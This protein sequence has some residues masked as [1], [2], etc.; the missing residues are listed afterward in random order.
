MVGL[1]I[2]LKDSSRED[3]VEHSLTVGSISVN[4]PN[5]V[6]F[7]PLIDW[8]GYQTFDS[9]GFDEKSNWPSKGDEVSSA[10]VLIQK[11]E[12]IWI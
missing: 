9:N 1:R 3:Q 7:G 2:V 12:Q 10:N 8:R 5:G 6:V 4:L 11:L